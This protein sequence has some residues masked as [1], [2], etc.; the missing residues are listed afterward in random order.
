MSDIALVWDSANGRCD[1][2]IENGDL[3]LDDGL[4]TAALI[5]ALVDRRAA[6]GDV[7]EGD[8][9][10]G[11]WADALILGVEDLWGSRLWVFAR[12]K[13]TA[14]TLEDARRAIEEAFAWLVTDKVASRL[15]VTAAFLG[16]TGLAWSIEIYRPDGTTSWYKF[17]RFWSG[18]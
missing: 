13:K 10:R 9:P 11:W 17:E 6:P 16:D 15:V 8:D 14:E 12:R 1:V 7:P 3:L 5:S 18:K 4:E 2:A